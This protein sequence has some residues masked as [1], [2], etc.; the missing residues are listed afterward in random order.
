VVTEPPSG[1]VSQSTSYAYDAVGQRLLKQGPQ[2]LRFYQYDPAGHLLEE[3]ILSNGSAVPER[4]Y[5]YLGGRPVALLLPGTGALFF[6][7][8]DR[9]DTPQFATDSAERAEWKAAYQPFGAIRPVILNLAQNLR[10]PGQ[11][12]DQETGH[13][14]NGFRDYDPALGRYLQSDPVGLSGG[15][16]TY[17]YVGENPINGIDPLGLCECGETPIEV[18]IEYSKVGPGY[19]VEVFAYDPATGAGFEAGGRGG[20]GRAVW[21]EP[22]TADVNTFQLKPHIQDFGRH[23]SDVFHVPVRHLPVT[24]CYKD[25]LKAE[26][27]AAKDINDWGTPY[28]PVPEWMPNTANSNTAANYLLNSIGA[29][30]T[31]ANDP[32]HWTPGL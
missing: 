26:R 16:N 11:Y 23:L 3:G 14:H 1:K 9:L 32:Q 6:L 13:Y 5:I 12:A 20:L 8:G 18:Y 31:A 24:L 17:A 28:F 10:L 2:G 21:G 30:T 4:D 29:D 27:K 22:L 15:L 19:H 7:H 25:A